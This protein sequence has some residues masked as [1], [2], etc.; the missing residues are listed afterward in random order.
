MSIIHFESLSIFSFTNFKS[1]VN[2]LND[3]FFDFFIIST[4]STKY[5]YSYIVLYF[6]IKK[7]VKN[8]KKWWR[9]DPHRA[10][11]V[12]TA[13]CMNIAKLVHCSSDKALCVDK[14]VVP[15]QFPAPS[16]GSLLTAFGVVGKSVGGILSF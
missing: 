2:T 10:V 11:P 4:I 12:L 8:S 7:I 6:R 15:W 13:F 3:N 16:G 1:F 5:Y 9:R 14:S